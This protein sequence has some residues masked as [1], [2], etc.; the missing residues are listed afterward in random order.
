MDGEGVSEE[1][2]VH[3]TPRNLRQSASPQCGDAACVA[4][5]EAETNFGGTDGRSNDAGMTRIL[6]SQE[7]C[8]ETQ[9]E[10]AMDRTEVERKPSNPGLTPIVDLGD[11]QRVDAATRNMLWGDVSMS[12][13]SPAHRL[14]LLAGQL[15]AT[16]RH[17]DKAYQPRRAA[18]ASSAKEGRASEGQSV[19]RAMT[20]L[21]PQAAD[22]APLQRCLLT[23]EVLRTSLG[24]MGPIAGEP[25]ENANAVG[26]YVRNS[27]TPSSRRMANID[28]MRGLRYAGPLIIPGQP[29]VDG[30]G[31]DAETGVPSI[32][33]HDGTS[34]S[35][36]GSREMHVDNLSILSRGSSATGASSRTLST[37]MPS[38][39]GS[40]VGESPQF[41]ETGS[42][43]RMYS[44][45][46]Y[47]PRV[48][49]KEVTPR[50]HRGSEP[51]SRQAMCEFSPIQQA[52]ESGERYCVQRTRQ[53]P[54]I[55]AP[56]GVS[57]PGGAST[58]QSTGWPTPSSSLGAAS[59]R[60]SAPNAEPRNEEGEREG[61]SLDEAG[62]G[63]SNRH[64]VQLSRQSATEGPAPARRE[65]DEEQR[66]EEN[67]H[68]AYPLGSHFGSES[69]V[70]TA[71]GARGNDGFAEA[72]IESNGDAEAATG[73]RRRRQE[74]G[75]D[76]CS[77][78]CQVLEDSEE[79]MDDEE[80]SIYLIP[81]NF[82]PFAA[83][84]GNQI[85][86]M[87]D[88]ELAQGIPIHTVRESESEE[89][90][91]LY[92]A[93]DSLNFTFSHSDASAIVQVQEVEEGGLPENRYIR[94]NF[95]FGAFAGRSPA[96]KFKS[97]MVEQASRGEYHADTP[98]SSA[99]QDEEG[100]EEMSFSERVH[101]FVATQMSGRG[102]QGPG[103][104]GT[105]AP[106]AGSVGTHESSSGREGNS[107]AAGELQA[108]A[109][110]EKGDGGVDRGTPQDVG[111]GQSGAALTAYQ[112]RAHG[113]FEAVVNTVTPVLSGDGG[114]AGDE[115]ERPQQHPLSPL[116][117]REHSDSSADISRTYPADLASYISLS[118]S[119]SSGATATP[120]E[121]NSATSVFTPQE[122]ARHTHL[123]GEYEP[124]Y[125]KYLYS[126]L[127]S[128]R[129]C[130]R[131]E[132][133]DTSK[134]RRTA[135]DASAHSVFKRFKLPNGRPSSATDA[136]P[137]GVSKGFALTLD[138]AQLF[139]DLYRSVKVLIGAKM[140]ENGYETERKHADGAMAS[141][142]SAENFN[143][144]ATS[145]SVSMSKS[146][147]RAAEPHRKVC[148]DAKK[149]LTEAVGKLKAVNALKAR[150]QECCRAATQH[151]CEVEKARE[152]YCSL[153]K[154]CRQLE[155]SIRQKEAFAELQ[156]KIWG[157]KKAR[158]EELRREIA[159]LAQRIRVRQATRSQR[160]QTER[161][162]AAIRNAYVATGIRVVPLDVG[163]PQLRWCFA[164][165][166]NADP[167]KRRCVRRFRRTWQNDLVQVAD[168]VVDELVERPLEYNRLKEDQ[169]FNPEINMVV[170]MRNCHTGGAQGE[171]LASF[172]RSVKFGEESS[173]EV[174][175]GIR[176]PRRRAHVPFFR[177]DE[178]PSSS[179]RSAKATPV[180]KRAPGGGWGLL[181]APCSGEGA[182]QQFAP[183][184]SAEAEGGGGLWMSPET[185]GV[186]RAAIA[187]V[188]WDEEMDVDEVNRGLRIVF[189]APRLKA[190]G[191]TARVWE[192]AL[193]RLLEAANRRI[194]RLTARLMLD[195]AAEHQSITLHALMREVVDYGSA[196]SARVR[197]VQRELLQLLGHT[198]GAAIGAAG[199]LMTLEVVLTPRDAGRPAL[200]CALEVDAYELLQTGS[201]ARAAQQLR[202]RALQPGHEALE[203]AVAH[204]HAR[205]LGPDDLERHAGLGRALLVRA[206]AR[207]G[208][209]G[210][211]R[212]RVERLLGTRVEV[213][214]GA[215]L[216]GGGAGPAVLEGLRG[217]VGR[218]VGALA[219]ARPRGRAVPA[220]GR[221]AGVPVRFRV[222]V[223]V[224]AVGV[225]PLGAPGQEVHGVT[226]PAVQQ[227]ADEHVAVGAPLE[228]RQQTLAQLLRQVTV[229]AVAAVVAIAAAG[230][231]GLRGREHGT[232]GHARCDIQVG[233]GVG[234]VADPES[235][236][237]LARCGEAADQV[238]KLG[239]QLA[240]DLGAVG[241]A[242]E[243][244]VEKTG[245]GKAAR[246]RVLLHLADFQLNL[247]LGLLREPLPGRADA[248]GGRV[249][250]AAQEQ[251]AV[252]DAELGVQAVVVALLVF[253]ALGLVPGGDLREGD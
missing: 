69:G 145:M 139:R 136:A 72:D 149:L 184:G 173:P 231:A 39:A 193:V 64:E 125:V 161:M 67:N 36:S 194:D 152:V 79:V 81:D 241:A 84:L 78:P 250:Q 177:S 88:A 23:P 96:E 195:K 134:E 154:E 66:A 56:P 15:N 212:R 141:R 234:D 208:E 225:G 253:Q 19:P 146:L 94:D 182:A 133:V 144:L 237:G 49:E 186:E 12:T 121:D 117:G 148:E 53:S 59:S 103:Q 132:A 172:T 217:Q 7:R 188:R 235:V 137:P 131:H 199:N 196:L 97:G 91:R 38:S 42:Q 247:L 8:T 228:R 166:Y 34:S 57:L 116:T 27:N 163:R 100:A 13:P 135:S 205:R 191:E 249:G 21:W 99:A 51:H 251:V 93:R 45:G 142:E 233:E 213:L 209:G 153:S 71:N 104:V 118:S 239:G 24:S 1:V 204:D 60:H 41:S 9:S 20:R 174:A 123:A 218:E 17:S 207:R 106:D 5:H 175:E 112:E 248:L 80:G 171:F 150:V 210:H 179:P 62:V 155:R 219:R 44:T 70:H 130:R 214:A 230:G 181:S 83:T 32:S 61:A 47:Q 169:Q 14:S 203:R 48:S 159:A 242:L 33:T 164:V 178:M 192:Q 43:A 31:D 221:A 22:V 126:N 183:L 46:S 68:R 26:S 215:Q 119:Y 202:V 167:N 229:A 85:E 200:R 87:V 2:G 238:G 201:Y 151:S 127:V 63:G 73:A 75:S 189:T 122:P 160:D 25:S 90:E 206:G 110:E 58:R 252:G 35:G 114:V 107:C 105:P 236:E 54:P 50:S 224:D 82:D 4:R 243:G 89:E 52:E 245:V 147:F 143:L 165:S 77:G 30:L 65:A 240:E 170:Y 129:S 113:G 95:S 162:L 180:S 120:R 211:A 156:L 98:H 6:R 223:V 244:Q 28:D 246:G 197:V 3:R 216:A 187:D 16:V 157:L 158:I 220:G 232:E 109:E 108:S 168:K 115:P 190:G 128:E 11:L 55:D 222:P 102:S 140:L 226:V 86:G 176:T 92:T 40:L 18:S 111:Y 29:P 124:V 37:M 74:D 185:R 227:L 198:S 138:A 101:R 76:V 10:D